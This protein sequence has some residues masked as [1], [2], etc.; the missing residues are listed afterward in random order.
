MSRHVRS[1]LVALTMGSVLQRIAQLLAAVVIARE[2]GPAGMGSYALGLSA[3]AILSLLCGAGIRSVVA[4]EAVASPEGAGDWI[5]AAIRLRLLGGAVLF[6]VYAVAAVLLTQSPWF[7][8]LCGA[9]V[10]PLAFDLKGL[11]D[12]A[13]RT[14]LEVVLESIASW[15]HLGLVAAVVFTAENN[16]LEWLAGAFLTSRVV[17]ALAARAR[18][19]SFPTTGFRPSLRKMVVSAGAVS[20]TQTVFEALCH[21]DVLVITVLTGTEIAGLYAVA[22]RIFVA[23]SFPAVQLARLLVPHLNHS[24][25]SGDSS[26]TLETALRASAYVTL[27]LAVGGWLVAESLCGLFG[28]EFAAAGWTLRWLLCACVLLGVGSQVGNTLFALR[29][30]ARYMASLWLGGAALGT[31]WLALVPTLGATGS[32]L[33]T[34]IAYAT[35]ILACFWFLRPHLHFRILQPL[36]PPLLLAVVV[37]LAAWLPGERVLAQLGLGAAAFGLGI[38]WLELRR[39]WSRLGEGLSQA[40]GLGA[41]PAAMTADEPLK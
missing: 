17:Y 24:A 33:G 11:A 37:G 36:R 35:V 40:S 32:A 26:R 29:H 10:F 25:R 5:R 4:R 12:S 15:L 28:A 22:L 2:L 9:S 1:A 8:L 30:T 7:W 38:W 18:L 16:H 21:C 34:C 41:S 13:S 19:A 31:A 20:V 3:A 39:G 27:P 23:V 6:S 14:P